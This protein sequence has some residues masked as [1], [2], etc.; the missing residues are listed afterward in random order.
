MRRTIEG[1][2]QTYTELADQNHDLLNY[3]NRAI[4]RIAQ[5]PPNTT[6]T[7]LAKQGV[8]KIPA[9]IQEIFYHMISLEPFTTWQ[10]DAERTVRLGKLSQVLEFLL[11]TPIFR[12]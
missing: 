7:Q 9:T 5:I 10:Q 8:T 4:N 1:W 6:V 3:V 2:I 11:F 12:E